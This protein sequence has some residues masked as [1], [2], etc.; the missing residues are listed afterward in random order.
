MKKIILVV[1]LVL[2]I[3][4]SLVLVLLLQPKE[5]VGAPSVDEMSVPAEQGP[6]E[7][8]PVAEGRYVAYSEAELAE[9]G[10]RTNVLFFYAAWCPECRAF[11]EAINTSDIP[12]GV[13][14]LQVDYDQ[15]TDLRQRYGVTL[16]S[17]F[18]SVAA[19]G[20]ARSTWVGYGKDKSVDAILENL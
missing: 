7:A 10:Y 12:D 18:V 19:D 14:I 9:S 20:T 8:Q 16:Q 4:A 3:F 13:Q 11:D 2:V 15:A 1:A 6:S 17:T 5:G